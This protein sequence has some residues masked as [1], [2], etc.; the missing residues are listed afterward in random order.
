MQTMTSS[1][2]EGLVALFLTSDK[3]SISLNSILRKK[4]W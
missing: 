1:L 4:D 2:K 3:K